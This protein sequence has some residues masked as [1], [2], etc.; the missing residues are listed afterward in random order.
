MRDLDEI[1]KEVYGIGGT[2]TLLSL[3]V[4]SKISEYEDMPSDDAIQG[5]FISINCAIE[6]I[7]NELEE[8]WFEVGRL[9]KEI[10][11]G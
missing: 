5:A 9:K 2:I 11:T 10:V 4:N 1:S 3:C 8:W 6:R 7:S